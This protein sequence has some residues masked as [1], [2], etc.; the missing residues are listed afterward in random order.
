MLK[1]V[2]SCVMYICHNFKNKKFK[3]SY[4]KRFKIRVVFQARRGGSQG[5]VREMR[6]RHQRVR[7]GGEG[8]GLLPELT[9]ASV[10]P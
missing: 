9:Q 5:T 4:K 1:M 7:T 6:I 3:L 8:G 10:C 2:K